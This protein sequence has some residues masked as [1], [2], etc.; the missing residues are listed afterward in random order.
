MK[1]MADEK[2]PPLPAA[3]YV[4]TMQVSHTKTE[5]YFVFGQLQPQSA[6]VA[7]LVAQVV[8]SPAHAK[9][10]MLALQENIRKYEEKYETIEAALPTPAPEE[11]R[12]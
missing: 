7:H 3:A 6:G 12:H 9:Q 10:V 1:T 4:N 11:S 8:T 2:K 5:F